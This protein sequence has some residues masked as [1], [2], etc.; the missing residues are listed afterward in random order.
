MDRKCRSLFA[1]N[2]KSR[3]VAGLILIDPF[4]QEQHDAIK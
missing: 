2:G 4:F 3:L 1:G